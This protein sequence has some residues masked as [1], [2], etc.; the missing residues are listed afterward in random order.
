MILTV[1]RVFGTALMVLGWS[2]N[3]L[4][5]AD[6]SRQ[7]TVMEE[8]SVDVGEAK[9]HF[10]WIRGNEV[11]VLFESG[12][13]MDS[14][15][16][17]ALVPAVANRTGATV[18]TYDRAGFGKSP[19][20]Q[21]PCRMDVEVGWLFAGLNHLGFDRNLI[22]VGHSYGGWIIHLIAGTY[23]DRVLGLVYVDPF[24]VEFVDQFGIAY[25]DQHPM[26]GNLPFKHDDPEHLTPYQK[27]LVRMVGDGMG[28]RTELLRQVKLPKELP[29]RLISSRKP[30]L[31]K[32][33]EQEAW[34]KAHRMFV[35]KNPQIK[36]IPAEQS[37]HGVPFQQP[38]LIVENI[39]ALYRSLRN[40][41]KIPK[42]RR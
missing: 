16:W 13:G 9:L 25:I 41:N 12:G 5:G 6:S 15:E 8:R 31:P 39:D 29:G 24:T 18:V 32:A 21:T 17:D 37:D 30:F 35:D 23:P 22:L 19:L 7:T 3:V 10:K 4:W 1:F 28:P 33:Q 20:P 36:L 40:E 27:A 38:D 14:S 34:W 2:G 42:E 11:V 26:C